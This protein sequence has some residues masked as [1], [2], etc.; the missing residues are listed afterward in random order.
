AA[1]NPLDVMA[2]ERFPDTK[3]AFIAGRDDK[4][5]GPQQRKVYEAAVK[6]GMRAEW[7]ELPGGHSWQVWRPGLERQ[8]PWLS[9]ET[10][11]IR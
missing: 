2:R 6:A 5:Y 10:G 8:L 3:A 1:V 11:L 7:V 9:R 4:T